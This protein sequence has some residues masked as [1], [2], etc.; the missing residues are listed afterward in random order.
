MTDNKIDPLNQLEHQLVSAFETHINA[1]VKG[2]LASARQEVKRLVSE[3]ESTRL[4]G[5]K[6]VEEQR[7][8]LESEKEAVAT[9]QKTQQVI[10]ELNVGGV[11][12]TTSAATLCKKPGTML[13]AM[14]SGRYEVLKGSDGRVFL[15][16]DGELFAY[17]LCYLRDDTVPVTLDTDELLLRRLQ[18]EFEFFNL[19]PMISREVA[20]VAGGA[21]E[22]DDSLRSVERYDPL[23]QMWT[24]LTPLSS[25]RHEFGLVGVSG[26]LFAVGGMD[27]DG[28]T[29]GVER[30]DLIN[31][32][33]E[34]LCDM[35]TPR[36]APG[37]CI[38]E[39]SIFVVGGLD[40]SG[41]ALLTCEKYDIATKQWQML[42]PM[43]EGRSY[44]GICVLNQSIFLVGGL[45]IQ[46][47]GEQSNAMKDVFKYDI[48]ADTW[49]S[50]ASLNIAR[51]RAGACALYGKIYVVGGHDTACLSSVERY[52][53]ATNRWT[54]VSSLSTGRDE[55]VLFTALGRLY[56]A[57]G[58]SLD[59]L[60]STEVEYFDPLL[61]TWIPSAP[62]LV[63]RSKHAGCVLSESISLFDSLLQD[64]GRTSSP[65]GSKRRKTKSRF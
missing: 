50:V 43:P 6:E 62:L 55:V 49:S 32:I 9:I 8:L 45:D 60:C 28:A 61:N 29:Q 33:W 37:V 38:F 12:Y 15:D 58:E 1:A 40:G 35:D 34:H 65:P 52:D 57:G 44:G 63:G 5:L 4:C 20:F 7:A 24:S 64:P 39:N 47:D 48:L 56:S 13:A 16:R 41:Q 19:E 31:H 30:Y 17:I 2:V 26:Y 22:S 46:D 25:P 21:D 3:I 36:R 54:E 14:F 10:V 59:E 53:P 18:L 27:M 23:R 51:H 11:H 42:A